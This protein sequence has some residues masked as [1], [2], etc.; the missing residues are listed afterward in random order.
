[1]DN[2]CPPAFHYCKFTYD[3]EFILVILKEAKHIYTQD[4]YRYFHRDPSAQ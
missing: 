2:I 3:R 1:M 4:G